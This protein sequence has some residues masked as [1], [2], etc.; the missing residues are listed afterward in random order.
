MDTN[1]QRGLADSAYNTRR[2]E[3]EQGVALLQAHL[4]GIQAL[5]DV[6]LAEFERYA[7]GLPD[8]VLRRCRHV[9]AEDE[10]TLEGVEALAQGRCRDLWAIDG[11]VSR[12]PAGRL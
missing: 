4:P 10:R 2:S 12:Q 7:D 8:N 1:K 3:C 9:I 6:S 11:R 5:R